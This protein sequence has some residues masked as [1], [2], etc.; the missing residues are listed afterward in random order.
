MDILTKLR[1]KKASEKR[2][3]LTDINRPLF[4]ALFGVSIYGKAARDEDVMELIVGQRDDPMVKI[5]ATFR[6]RQKAEGAEW[7]KQKDGTIIDKNGF[8]VLQP[9][10]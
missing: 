4:T 8:I 2:L 10:M 3:V 1:E 6:A 9:K 7:K 5:R